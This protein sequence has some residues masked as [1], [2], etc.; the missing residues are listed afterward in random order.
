MNKSII[1]STLCCLLMMSGCSTDDSMKSG[2][3]VVKV[4]PS[5]SG[6]LFGP[7]IDGESYYNDP[8]SYVSSISREIPFGNVTIEAMPN[9]NSYFDNWSG[10]FISKENPLHFIMNGNVNLVA[11]FFTFKEIKINQIGEGFI[12]SKSSF[13]EQKKIQTLEFLAS[14]KELWEFT[15]WTGDIESQENPYILTRSFDDNREIVITANF[16][17]ITREYQGPKIESYT[18]SPQE[19]DIT[20]SSQVVTVTA[21]VTDESGVGEAPIVYI[22]KSGSSSAT[23][24]TGLLKRIS[25]D[26]K[27]GVYEVKIT[28]PQGLEPGEWK[29][30]SNS[31]YDIYRNES[32]WPVYPTSEKKIL[33][34]I[35]K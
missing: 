18:F 3:L 31:F 13:N 25:G 10:D 34:V 1:Y 9:E 24:Q 21:H 29:V 15:G 12:S 5:G 4:A 23:Q 27:D 35:S 30:F 11:N 6:K 2:M 16:K 8:S 22:E 17:Q 20:N 33:N 28:I 19:I 26:A 7:M 32:V 14:P